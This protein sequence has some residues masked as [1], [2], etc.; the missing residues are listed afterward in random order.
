MCRPPVLGDPWPPREHPFD[1]C[2]RRKIMTADVS[3]PNSGA[4]PA[5]HTGLG[6]IGVGVFGIAAVLIG[7]VLLFNP[8]AAARTLALLIGL[9]L[10]IAGCLEM[11]LSWDSDRR[12]L[13]FLPGAVLVL[14]GLLAAFWPGVTLLTLAVLTGVSLM[15]QGMSRALLAF[16]SRSDIPGWGWLA[17]AGVFNFIVGVLALAWPEATVLVLSLILGVQIL[18]FGVLLVVAAFRGSRPRA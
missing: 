13:A 2:E 14:G 17:L 12:V 8:F 5:R 7:G 18:V 4:P 16:V 11:S 1:S 3:N 9:A 10:V 6:R 15:I